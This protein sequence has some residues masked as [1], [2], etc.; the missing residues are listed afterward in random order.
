MVA[1]SNREGK[2]LLFIEKR[3]ALSACKSTQKEPFYQNDRCFCHQSQRWGCY[4]A[5]PGRA[6]AWRFNFLTNCYIKS[7]KQ[8]KNLSVNPFQFL[9]LNI[10]RLTLL[11]LSFLP[12]LT[13]VGC[14]PVRSGQASLRNPLYSI[15]NAN[16][17]SQ[18]EES[19]R[20]EI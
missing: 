16:C 5:S 13:A 14:R 2:S 17:K 18:N 11:L 10:R 20:F 4:R 7:Y 3:I 12:G 8:D 1:K 15:Q 19:K 9:G 6:P